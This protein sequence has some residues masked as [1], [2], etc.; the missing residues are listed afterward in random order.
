MAKNRRRGELERD[1]GDKAEDAPDGEKRSVTR[2]AP[3]LRLL[4]LLMLGIAIALYFFSGLDDYLT[5]RAL[6]ENRDRLLA[7]VSGNY[8]T[9]A[10]LYMAL[11]ILVVALSLPGGLLLTVTGGFL[12]G[13]LAGGLMTVVAATIGAT[14]IFLIAATSLGAPLRAR[15]G[16]WLG[17]VEAGFAKNATSY[18]LFLRLVPLFPFWLVNVAPAFL[19][20]SLGTYVITTLIGIIPG[21]FAF[22][23]LGRGLDS[24]ITER[25]GAYRACLDRGGAEC[26]IDFEFTSLLTGEMLVALA[27]L[28]FLALVPVV[29]KRLRGDKK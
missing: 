2:A 10:T 17:K 21:T 27:A 29:V 15:A 14:L 25:Q 6:S 23:Y 13:W 9:A 18:L 11:Y 12:F 26:R 24:I 4:P 16:P 20:V 3:L 1:A 19:G 8:A 5:F 28:G 7:F 22:A